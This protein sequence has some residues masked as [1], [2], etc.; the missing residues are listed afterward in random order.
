MSA[1]TVSGQYRRVGT[2][3]YSGDA[4]IN[5]IVLSDNYTD[6]RSG[7]LTGNVE[8]SANVADGTGVVYVSNTLDPATSIDVRYVV[9]RWPD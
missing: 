2:L 7:T 1:S 4:T 3:T 6:A 8:F 9:R 5:D